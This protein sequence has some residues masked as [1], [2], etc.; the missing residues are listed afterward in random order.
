M[1][2]DRLLT[3]EGNALEGNDTARLTAYEGAVNTLN[4]QRRVGS[5]LSVHDVNTL[6]PQ[7]RTA[8]NIHAYILFILVLI[9]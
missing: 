4:S 7:I 1:Y 9:E 3:Y 2:S 5:S 8:V 6:A